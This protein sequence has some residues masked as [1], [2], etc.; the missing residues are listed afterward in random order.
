MYR[1]CKNYDI[2]GD[3]QGLPETERV[4]GQRGKDEGRGD[5]LG[6]HVIP[7][8]L[9]EIFDQPQNKMRTKRAKFW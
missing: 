7:T 1:V 6:G 9:R 3:M 8:Y 2:Y 4:S 5:L